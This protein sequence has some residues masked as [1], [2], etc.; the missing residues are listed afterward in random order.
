MPPPDANEISG[1]F[2]ALSISDSRAERT[3]KLN[4]VREQLLRPDFDPSALPS[5]LT[6]IFAYYPTYTDRQSRNL[7]KGCFTDIIK[8]TPNLD[9]LRP[10]LASLTEEAHKTSI[11]P[12]GAFV[13]VDWCALL[14]QD[15]SAH[16]I[17]RHIGL[18]L[19]SANASALEL[20]IGSSAKSSIKQSALAAT[21]KGLRQLFSAPGID[22][23]ALKGIVKKLT[24][25]DTRPC[26]RNAPFLGLVAGTCAQIPRVSS[27]FEPLAVSIY[28]YYSR[29][30]LGSRIVLPK[31]IAAGL[32][33]FFQNF[34]TQSSLEEELVPALDRALLR[35]PEIVLNDLVTPLIDSLPKTIDLSAS[36]HKRLLKSLLSHTNSTNPRIRNGALNAFRKVASHCH[37]AKTLEEVAKEL[38]QPLTSWK[39]PSAE[40]R[41]NYCQ[42]LA[43]IP[44]SDTLC[45]LIPEEL[46][47]VTLKDVND[48]AIDAQANAIS[49]HMEYAFSH[50]FEV[51]AFVMKT[52]REGLHSKKITVRKV[53]ALHFGKVLW[54]LFGPCIRKEN[55]QSFIQGTLHTL[56]GVFRQVAPNPS[57]A[58]QTGL[59]TVVHICAALLLDMDRPYS[60]TNR[61]EIFEYTLLSIGRMSYLLTPRIYTKL[62]SEED[63]IWAIRALAGLADSYI[64]D[65]PPE[66]AMAWS[67]AFIYFISISPAKPLVRREVTMALSM[68][69]IRNPDTISRIIIEGIWKWIHHV[70]KEARDSAAVAAKCGNTQLHAVIRAI[71]IPPGKGGKCPDPNLIRVAKHQ[72]L[73]LQVMCRHPILP[74]VSWIDLCQHMT[75]DPG[76]LVEDYADEAMFRLDSHNMQSSPRPSPDLMQAVYNAAAELAFIS[77]DTIVPM[78]VSNLERDLDVTQME[79]ISPHEAAI[80]KTPKGQ[81]YLDP[82]TSKEPPKIDKNSKDYPTLKWEAEVRRDIANRNGKSAPSLDEIRRL[83]ALL[84]LQNIARREVSEY[85]FKFRRGLGIITSLAN[86]NSVGAAIWMAPVVDL[87]LAFIAAGSSIVIDDAASMAFIACA[88]HVSNRLG[89]LRPFIGIAIL[90]SM[91]S[92]QLDA[93]LTAE[94]FGDLVTRVLYRLK[95]T[96]EQRAFDPVSLS[97]ILPLI[98]SVLKQNGLGKTAAEEI[99]EQVILSLEFLACQTDALANKSLPRTRILSSLITSMQKYNQHYKIIKDCLQDFCRCIAGNFSEEEIK[100][101]LQGAILP[102]VAVRKSVLQ[103]INA[104]IDLRFMYFS[105]EI[106]IECHDEVAEIVDLA[107]DIWHESEFEI[108]VEH[109]PKL[110]PYLES[111]DIQLRLA[112]SRA[113]GAA[114]KKL[115]EVAYY[116]LKT[117]TRSYIGKAKPIVPLQ[118]KFGIPSKTNSKD[119]WEARHGAALA[120]K[121]ISTFIRD[122]SLTFFIEFLINE[123]PLA[124]RS[125]M[126]RD[127]MIDAGT[128]AITKNGKSQIN[129]L[130]AIFERGLEKPDSGLDQVN[131]ALVIM[132]GAL[133]RHLE[134]SDERVPMVIKKLLETLSTPSETVQYAIAE[135]LPPLLRVRRLDLPIYVQ[136]MTDQLLK[137]SKYAA[138]RGAAYGL[139]A[140][141][142][143]RGI[144]ALREYR[145]LTTLK[146]A[147]DNK[148]D[149][150]C[151][152]GAL[153]AYELFASVLGNVFE[154]YI[155]QI[156]PVLLTSFGDTSLD[157][158]NGCLDAAKVCF[159]NLSS[160]GV[161][162]IL[163]TLLEGLDDQ[164]WRSKKGACDLLGAMAYLDPEQLAL[165]LPD[166]IPPLTNVLSDSHKEVRS[167]ANRSLQRFGDVIVNP[168][169]KGLV[170]IL[171]KALS[172]PTKYT[173]DAL[174]SLIKV[175]FTHYL[176]SPSLA[177]IVR[178]LERGLSDRSSTKR[179]S[180]Q[181]IGS[182]AHLADRKDLVSHLPTLVAGLKLAVVDPVPT[183]RATA[184]KALGSLVEK[185]GEDALPD[186]IPSLMVTLRSDSGAGDRLGSAQALSEVLAGLGTARL[187]EM[188]PTILQSVTSSKPFVREG[189]MTLFIF[190][191]ACFGN[192]FVA[193]LSR[194]IPPILSGLADDVESIR[195]TSLRAGR[196]LVKNFANRSVD[197][198]LPELERGLSHDSH[199]IRLSSVELVGDLLFNLT[200]IA[201]EETPEGKEAVGEL[202]SSLLDVLGEK[203][204]DKVLAS[205]YICRCDTSGLV[206]GAAIN[207]WKALVPNPRVLREIVPTITQQIIRRL[208]S[209]SMEQKTIAGNA[210]GELIRK[211]GDGVLSSLL[212][213]L[214]EGLQKTRDTDAKQGIC[215]ALRELILS[216]SPE[217]LEEHENTLVSVVRIALVD[218][219]DDVREVAAEA[220]DALQ[221]SFGN[222]S[223]NQVMPYLLD[224]LQAKDMAENALAALLTLLKDSA[225]ANFILPILI[226]SLITAPI[227][228]FNARALASLAAVAGSSVLR[229]LPTI[230]SSLM[231]AI[232][233]AHDDELLKDLNG[234]FDTVLASLDESDGLNSAM[235]IMFL[236][237]KHDDH[238]KRRVA[239]SR[240]AVFF[241]EAQ[242]DYSRYYQELIRVLL[243]S[244]D[245]RDSQVVEAGWNAL[246][247]LSKR[248]PKEDMESLTPY[249]R[250]ILSGVGVPGVNLPGFKLPK[251]IG[252][253]LPIFMQGLMNGTAEQR[254]QAALAMSDIIDKASADSLKPYV[255]Q[256]T[257]SL[258]R[259]MS[260]RSV[261]L[262]AAVLLTLDN[263]L[264]KTPAFL[265]QFMPQL[266]RVFTKSLADTSSTTIR[267]RAAKAL[268]TLITL[269]PRLDPLVSELVTG[270]KME[271]SGIKIAM[272]KALYE[273]VTKAGD[274]MSGPSKT[275]ILT[276][277]EVD[278]ANTDD[279]MAACYSRL[280]GAVIQLLPSETIPNLL[281]T[282]AVNRNV[283]K[284]TMLNLNAVLVE[285]PEFLV[286]PPFTEN[287]P[288]VISIGIRKKDTQISENSIIASGKYL[289]SKP[290]VKPFELTR[291]VFTA[292]SEAIQPDSPSNS[293][294]LGLVVLRTICRLNGAITKPHI[295]LLAPNIFAN[296]RDVL[297]PVKL[298]AEAAFLA[299]FNVAESESKEFDKY[300]L[301]LKEEDTPQKRSMAEWFKRTALRL[302]S[303]ARETEGQSSDEVD[304]E[305]EIWSV[306]KVD[307]GEGAFD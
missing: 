131:E 52:F 184:S 124:D 229:R 263:M 62:A 159:A 258:I 31:H 37:D 288:L 15:L 243:V 228:A 294:R 93:K 88:N 232:V 223:I 34:V 17:W 217:L 192:S 250:Q 85:C 216:A 212:P 50:G 300:M 173:N 230:L 172:D 193:Y 84:D 204:R 205:I 4:S 105:E 188:L 272:L 108:E 106:W 110:F 298:S 199:R 148:K 233:V 164:Q 182:L 264:E 306:G 179:K 269:K 143:S 1:A 283:T 13:L 53:W 273:V 72:L 299:L 112:T 115:R 197:L 218:S 58:A 79:G 102:Q 186:L 123:G 175:S 74:Q 296:V 122:E 211:A 120:L 220:F 302:G 187:E 125:P 83:E 28:S 38:L 40:H 2:R 99:D 39:L 75:I 8:A 104:E 301:G 254:T 262:R 162:H 210:L 181:I 307:L 147:I 81:P 275:A 5:I 128:T 127:A 255:I 117:L 36:L 163:P 161:K 280:L 237:T 279:E 297:L 196:L 238:R 191:P 183:T 201:Q 266:Q 96:A 167:A 277:V 32:H 68:S 7:I 6:S 44:S 274:I 118:D 282:H 59:I 244:F 56:F 25:P 236:F 100:E 30:I 206:R 20:C 227:S 265:K 289:L 190:L 166:I 19:L 256:M 168:E 78:L 41:T 80:Y 43:S 54:P 174:D 47:P 133:A 290:L 42:M 64:K 293:R 16:E 271:D 150:N 246:N 200:G 185:L 145:I 285:S 109:Y 158:R 142:S 33:E 202:G 194:V 48:L 21:R 60:V 29:E 153:I 295:S 247:E 12:T 46:A 35:A 171:L 222:K 134:A 70:E 152:Q 114:A 203:K 146:G 63:Q 253:V 178:I 155:I 27:L 89:A 22:E 305:R 92:S 103:A 176:D 116:M 259:V 284:T 98:F 86:G 242:V 45:T 239:N 94:P 77:P 225:R 291:D 95:F 207:V 234:S 261:D 241:S 270:S 189:F 137:S 257:G 136:D 11:A 252:A 213:T 235:S 268:G 135:C 304:D 139:A 76:A 156:V 9:L 276:I 119:P 249:T 208:G 113:L 87:L 130:M 51:A 303:Q 219:H 69:F 10:F 55:V 111:P 177:L 245:D 169:I 126:V 91:P 65:L 209:A 154:P 14:V 195:E 260:E 61:H 57:A 97:Y 287:V 132:Y 101:L 140:I 144:G 160:Y 66:S 121:E 149:P 73:E 157:V 49:T 90:R 107:N 23:E 224:Q 24:T 248:L 129:Q 141:V 214:E 18:E 180:A 198:L 278:A 3:E 292:L 251:G 82:S 221:Q 215:I 281:K 231:E 151:R 26:V 170:G 240:L 286:V 67:Q 267:S 71:C 138:R 226:P 165:S